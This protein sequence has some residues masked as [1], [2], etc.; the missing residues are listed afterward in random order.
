MS[1]S[2]ENLPSL[3]ESL[4]AS[5]ALP[6]RLIADLIEMLERV[7]GLLLEHYNNTD[8]LAVT[9]KADDSPVTRADEDAHQAIKAD[10]NRLTPDIPVL[11]EESP[12]EQVADRLTWPAC[13]VVDPLDG[14]KEFIGRT[15]EFSINIALVVD[16][17]PVLGLISV[18][19]R[20]HH[21]IGIPGQGAWVVKS[22]EVTALRGIQ[23]DTEKPVGVLASKR[24]HPKKVEAVLSK[25]LSV[26]DGVVRINAGS[27]LKFCALVEGEAVIY[28]RTSPCYE[29]DVAAGDALVHGAGGFL[30]DGAGE[31]LRYNRR[32]SLLVEHF[33]AGTDSSVDWVALLS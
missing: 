18:P 20:A 14:T 28:P 33:I 7:D 11:S 19:V 32:E 3:P 6:E 13:W 8:P 4:R 10:L 12:D 29:W 22:G 24:H 31:T 30:V 21:Y 2:A 26:G 23:V 27:A 5:L 25:L 17:R 15:D 1:L 9:R 16:D